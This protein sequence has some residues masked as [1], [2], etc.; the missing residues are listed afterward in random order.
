MS[1][2]LEV[3]GFL[4]CLYAAATRP[5]L[6]RLLNLLNGLYRFDL[7]RA[8]EEVTPALNR[9]RSDVGCPATSRFRG[10]LDMAPPTDI[11]IT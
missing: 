6:L 2:E 10:T 4:H 11:R 9:E 7:I 5:L 3:F 1:F 8:L